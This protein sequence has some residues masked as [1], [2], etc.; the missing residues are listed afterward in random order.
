MLATGAG[1]E[2][3]V[4]IGVVVFAGVVGATLLTLFVVPVA[5]SRLARATGSP[6]EVGRRLER[7][8]DE[9]GP[10]RPRIVHAAEGGAAAAPEAGSASRGSGR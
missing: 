9:G 7:E 5:Y 3:R 8:M 2:T 4:Q 1:A 10:P 6:G